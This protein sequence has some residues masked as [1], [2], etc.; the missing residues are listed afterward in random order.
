MP[1]G[2]LRLAYLGTG[3][4]DRHASGTPAT[5]RRRV[6]VTGGLGRI[7]RELVPLLVAEGRS[8]TVIDP[9]VPAVP[10]PPGV[11]LVRGSAGD[12]PLLE[13]LAEEGLPGVVVHLGGPPWGGAGRPVREAYAAI[14][15][16]G[17]RLLWRVV[18]WRAGL[19]LAS[20]ALVY[21]EAGAGGVGPATPCLPGEAAGEAALALE[22]AAARALREAGLP[23]AALRLFLVA[24]PEALEREEG[25]RV[26][27]HLD[28][29]TPHQAARAF[30]DAAERVERGETLGAY[31]L[32]SGTS[33]RLALPLAWGVA[34][35]SVLIAGPA[36][37]APDP[38]GEG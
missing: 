34:Y 16:V 38:P 24:D 20:T 25:P 6:W 2:R 26:T 15:E 9:A 4:L 3:P 27:R 7:G 17:L 19:V 32:T 1:D 30:L 12:G 21:G 10:L 8:V 14:L 13:A 5:A 29:L 23:W 33:R 31:P 11:T 35:P 36:P 37:T 28:L 18:G 22:R